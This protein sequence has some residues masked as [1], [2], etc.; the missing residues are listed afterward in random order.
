M[1]SRFSRRLITLFTAAAVA[2]TPA[3]GQAQTSE[4]SDSSGSSTYDGQPLSSIDPAYD[5]PASL[6]VELS[7]QPGNI[8]HL[9]NLYRAFHQLS[10]DARLPIPNI[11]G[12]QTPYTQDKERDFAAPVRLAAPG[13]HPGTHGQ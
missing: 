12:T 2:L 13:R 7:K 10:P 3:V 11:W 6:L 5:I 9:N 4:S 8:H 1:S